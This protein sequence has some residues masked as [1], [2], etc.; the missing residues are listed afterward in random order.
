[1]E[2]RRGEEVM[3]SKATSTTQSEVASVSYVESVVGSIS[4]EF[5]G[6]FDA[7]ASCH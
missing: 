7:I 5:V 6:A 2:T 4:D 1:M 3:M